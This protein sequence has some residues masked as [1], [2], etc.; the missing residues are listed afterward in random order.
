MGLE[1]HPVS[2]F[3]PLGN[4]L[5]KIFLLNYLTT[6]P[7]SHLAEPGPLDVRV[8]LVAHTP[9]HPV[10]VHGVNDGGGVLGALGPL[11]SLQEEGIIVASLLSE[12]LV[13]LETLS[14]VRI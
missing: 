3:T 1:L 5:E 11:Y 2:T 10:V 7:V 6:I 4:A 13:L 14:N 9:D 8:L 12:Q